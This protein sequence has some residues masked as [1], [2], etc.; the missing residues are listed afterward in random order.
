M[1]LL[2]FTEYQERQLWV[3]PTKIK[4][5]QLPQLFQFLDCETIDVP[6]WINIQMEPCGHLIP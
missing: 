6:D 5:F 4:P 3:L 1:G 2:S